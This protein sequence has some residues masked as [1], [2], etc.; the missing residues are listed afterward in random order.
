M[1]SIIEEYTGK[2][3]DLI[4]AIRV[5]QSKGWLHADFYVTDALA[6][7][8]HF[9]N[10]KWTRSELLKSIPDRVQDNQYTEIKWVRDKYTHFTRR[11]IDTLINSQTVK[12][13]KI[14]G[15]YIYTY[16]E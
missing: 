13:G 2:S 3:V 16:E 4:S 1:L 7:L 6:I 11:T 14:A 15:Y 12:L 9:T 8:N 10:K 5:C